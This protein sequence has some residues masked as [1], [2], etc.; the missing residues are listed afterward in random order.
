M[1]HEAPV[2]AVVGGGILGLSAARALSRRVPNARVIVLEKEPE[3]GRHQ[4]GRASGV[5]H[6]GVY[7]TPGSLKARLCVQGAKLLVQFCEERAIPFQRCGKV[8]VATT[9]DE[10]PRLEELH[11]RAVANGVEGA[12]LIDAERLAELEPH[13]AGVRAL[14][15]PTT[16]IVDFVKVAR[17]YADDVEAAGGSVLA[18]HEVTAVTSR[19]QGVLLTTSAGE[20]EASYAVACAGVYADRVARLCGGSAE[21]RIIPFRGDYYVLRQERRNLVNGLVYPVPDPTFPFLGIHTTLRPD[22]S[23]WLGPNAVLA[24]ARDGYGRF[25]VRPRDLVETLGT[26]GFRRLARRHWRTGTAELVRDYSRRLFVASARRL[27]PDL[28]TEDVRR[29]PAGI[30]AQAIAPDGSLVDDFVFEAGDRMLHM[31]NAPSPGATS[32]L[33]I[34]D[35]IATM[36]V[37]TFSLS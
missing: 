20:I 21:P 28:R 25:H 16:G 3:I 24:F 17:A 8:I 11:R 22:G 15:V 4:T 32:S 19:R 35:T 34:G 27:I 10:L 37:E 26:R 5:V 23:I 6:S 13:A 30:R 14:H 12:E 7:Y 31:R 1:T 18:G 33:P 2:V 9:V 36:A 29:G